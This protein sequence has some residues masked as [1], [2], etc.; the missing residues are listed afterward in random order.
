MAIVGTILCVLAERVAEQVVENDQ[1]RQL[2]DA[3]RARGIQQMIDAGLSVTKVAKILRA[4]E[5]SRLA[6]GSMMLGAVSFW[7]GICHGCVTWASS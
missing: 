5:N 2:T 1:R 7:L 4:A 6:R 3:Q